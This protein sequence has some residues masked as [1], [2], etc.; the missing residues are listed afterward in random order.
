MD[1]QVGAPQEIT[2]QEAMDR[3][4]HDIHTMSEG[5]VYKLLSCAV[6]PRPIAW[7]STVSA[8]GVNNLAPFSFFNVASRNPATLMISIGER[9][10]FPGE[11]KDTLVNI[12][13]TGNF[14]VNIPS[15]ET[16]EAV[17][18]SFATVHA[19]VDEFELSGMTPVT[20]HSVAAPSV[21]QSLVSLECELLQEVKLGTD[22]LVL[23]SV[24]SVTSR[25]GLLSED[26]HVDTREHH[27]L[28]RL[29]GPF[30]TTAMNRVA[31]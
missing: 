13:E 10:G 9:I 3:T 23:G 12:R 29:A 2:P 16:V 11:P 8:A 6:Q 28:G 22:T 24:L 7:I 17:T 30:Y 15:A 20:S 4:R 25:A 5:D 27:F 18:S 14:V 1:T 21:L 19:D 31:Q 26:L